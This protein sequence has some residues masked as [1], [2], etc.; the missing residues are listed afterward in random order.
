MVN[1]RGEG[2]RFTA[3]TEHISMVIL[4]GERVNRGELFDQD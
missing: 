3:T 4:K 1:V 2:T